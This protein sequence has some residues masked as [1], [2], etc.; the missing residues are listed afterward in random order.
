MPVAYTEW[1]K[2][3]RE[4][5]NSINMPMDDWQKNW[6]FDFAAEYQAGGD[7]GKA[8]EKAN[9]YWWQQQNRALNQEC[10]RDSNCWLPQ[11]HQG[12]CQP[13]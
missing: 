2:D 11:G 13:L 12:D 8:A 1:L 10:K 4:A 5:L 9:R 7:P 3:V 6:Q